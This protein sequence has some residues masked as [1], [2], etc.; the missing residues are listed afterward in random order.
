M[1][2]IVLGEDAHLAFPIISYKQQSGDIVLAKAFHNIE[3]DETY[4]EDIIDIEN[5]LQKFFKKG[6]LSIV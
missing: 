3:V 5:Q 1:C 2:T 6:L 4:F